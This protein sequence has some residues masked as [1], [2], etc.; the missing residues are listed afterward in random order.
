MMKMISKYFP[1]EQ[2]FPAPTDYQR[3][4]RLKKRHDTENEQEDN[5][6]RLLLTESVAVGKIV[7][8]RILRLFD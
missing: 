8:L 5:R 1:R 6:Q 4:S 7:L 2:S 3:W